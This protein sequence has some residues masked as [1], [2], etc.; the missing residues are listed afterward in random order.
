L[1]T[2]FKSNV[3]AGAHYVAIW[4]F[5][6]ALC[7]HWWAMMSSAL[8]TLVGLYALWERKSNQWIVA[9][10]IGAALLFFVAAA[11][12]AWNEERI[13]LEDEIA[14]GGRPDLTA[15]FEVVG[16]PPRTMLILHNSS[17]A[18]AVGVNIQDIHSGTKVL[19]FSSPNPVRSGVPGTWVNC[20]ILENGIQQK[21]D[22]LPL[23]SGMTF[24]GQVSPLFYLRIIFSSLDSRRSW[25]LSIPF[26][27][28]TLERK[29]CMGQQ[30]ID[31]TGRQS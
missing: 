4:E 10:S 20:W 24:V 8:L 21:D 15:Q 18:P 19:R 26:W 3:I 11:F 30:T 7:K 17:P 1:L 16:S 14:K 25:M 12:L 2:V 29:I 27:Y 9:A 28:D 6:K 31:P 22:V 5:I 23:F 13:G